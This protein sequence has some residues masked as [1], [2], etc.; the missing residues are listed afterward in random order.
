MIKKLELILFLLTFTSISLMAQR[1]RNYV[2][3]F[4]CTQSM[5]NQ[6]N[7]WQPTKRYLRDDITKLDNNSTITIIPFQNQA[8]NAIQFD[9]QHF[10]W[11]EIEKQ[12]DEY[13]KTASG[14]NICNAWDN[15]IRF[16]NSNKD[17]YFI[18]LTDGLDTYEKTQGVCKR[19]SNWCGKYKNSY[20]FY[21]MLT[22]FAKD[23]QLIS[24]INSCSSVFMIDAK[25]HLKPFGAFT[26]NE[27][28]V[29]TLDL[30][31]CRRLT[32][33]TSGNYKAH[34][35]CN[36]PLFKVDVIG[37]IKNGR[38]FVK[39]SPRMPISNITKR[40]AGKDFYNF[41][42][43]IT[44]DNVK[45]LNPQ[46]SVDV[47]NKP[48]RVLN[49]PTEEID[50]GDASYYKSF[51]FWKERKQ[52]TL[53]TDLKAE[54]NKAAMTIHSSVTM[55][56]EPT[57]KN[58]G[59]TVLFNGKPCKD[60]E[61]T[62]NPSM[63]Q[64]ILSI[65]FDKD[66]KTGKRYLK[67]SP[68]D[69]SVYQLERINDDPSG[70]YELTLRAHYAINMNPLEKWLIISIV[71]II[72]F[73]TTIYVIGHLSSK[74]IKGISSICILEPYINEKIT[75]KGAKRVIFS[76]KPKKQNLI[77]RFFTG[78]IIYECNGNWEEE[79]ELY[80]KSK[81]E[82]GALF[83]GYYGIKPD[84]DNILDNYTEFYIITHY[85]TKKNFKI[86]LQ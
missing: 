21:V 67:L 60:N 81:G 80:P 62:F 31:K 8:F 9:R 69:G 45:V 20:A 26:P 25:N 51:L 7:I 68:V 18:L 44:A 66:S 57:D 43:N 50:L 72:A 35:S 78:K 34:V 64:S 3:L 2:Y 40:L 56:V 61:I 63:K 32:F 23:P 6:V 55:K 84:N 42:A 86:N 30:Q 59:F 12:L 71:L 52:D 77:N 10:N 27:L 1:E 28:H 73:L 13:I 83:H 46:I 53:T 70:D 16:L 36:D 82:V 76:K 15:G 38:V 17:N 74:K 19:I 75:V 49:M 85:E 24:A 65:V 4:D 11:N 47:S 79:W 29:S 22:K 37:T 58:E 48:E 14:T 41:S 33:S 5:I 39:V 54:F